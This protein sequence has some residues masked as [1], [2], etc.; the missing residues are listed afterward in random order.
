MWTRK[1][2]IQ[3]EEQ[4]E[5]VWTYTYTYVVGETFSYDMQVS[6]EPSCNIQSNNDRAHKYTWNGSKDIIRLGKSRVL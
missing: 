1:C 2:L 3:P 6:I 5:L 4:L